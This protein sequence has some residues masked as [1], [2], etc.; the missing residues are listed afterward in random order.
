TMTSAN[1]PM[2][3]ALRKRLELLP[4]VAPRAPLLRVSLRFTRS[5]YKAGAT[6]K[7]KMVEIETPMVN[8]RTRQSN[9]KRSN[10]SAVFE[11]S[12]NIQSDA[13][14]QTITAPMPPR[15]ASPSD[16]MTSGVINRNREAPNADRTANSRARAMA[17]ARR[18]LARFE[19]AI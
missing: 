8:P 18:K 17:R 13:Q 9:R 5:A 3:S 15:M 4:L 11:A 2:T 14:R 19:Q 1:C 12:R 7:K 10:D 6:P 16:S